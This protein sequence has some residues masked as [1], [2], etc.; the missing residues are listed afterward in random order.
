MAQD[1]TPDFY[2][3]LIEIENLDYIKDISGDFAR[4]QKLIQAGCGVM[5]GGDPF[6]PYA[7]MAGAVGMV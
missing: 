4:L 7:L 6:A 5:S 3:R 1:I 2:R